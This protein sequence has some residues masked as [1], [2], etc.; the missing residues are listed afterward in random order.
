MDFNIFA[1][2]LDD[3]KE[4]GLTLFDKVSRRRGTPIMRD[5]I[6]E[7]RNGKSRLVA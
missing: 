2:D 1:L 3:V 7:N 5:R 4:Q 6:W